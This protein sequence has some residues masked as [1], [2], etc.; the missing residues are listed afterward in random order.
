[1]YVDY[2]LHCTRLL[3]LAHKRASER[4]SERVYALLA[5][6]GLCCSPT[7]EAEFHAR[8]LQKSRSRCWDLTSV[9]VPSSRE[10]AAIA[11]RETRMRRLFHR[12]SCNLTRGSS[13]TV[14]I[15]IKIMYV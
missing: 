5:A 10:K 13:M 14:S 3:M 1:M 9:T 7:S 4:L 15:N 2:F 6:P 11:E 12:A 8:R